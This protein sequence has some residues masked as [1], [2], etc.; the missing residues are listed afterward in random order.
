MCRRLPAL[1]ALVVLAAAVPL[2]AAPP[3]AAKVLAEASATAARTGKN[4]LVIFHASWCGYCRRMASYTA[5]P[6]VRQTLDRHLEV[7]WLDVLERGSAKG[8]ENPG[9]DAVLTRLGG[10]GS[11]LP[12]Y[13]V[14]DPRGTLL[15]NSIRPATGR[16]TGF[17]ETGEEVA[18][19]LDTI[20]AGAPRLTA[21]ELDTLHAP[22]V[23]RH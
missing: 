12:F 18:H 5:M 20:H 6:S 13:A 21:A 23:K 4:V 8:L 7:V 10:S 22:F 11:G 15:G 14:L 2:R 16:N 3:D 9:G 1:L 19:F 17:P